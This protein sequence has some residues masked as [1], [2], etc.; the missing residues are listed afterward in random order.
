M[1]DIDGSLVRWNTIL[2]KYANGLHAY[3]RYVFN[4]YANDLRDELQMNLFNLMLESSITN[5]M[6]INSTLALQLVYLLID[7]T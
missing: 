3:I 5:Q 1:A 4:D 7:L 6:S 2:C